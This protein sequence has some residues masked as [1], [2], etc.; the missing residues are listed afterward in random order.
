M[1][2]QDPQ[3]SAER[4]LALALAGAYPDA[5][6]AFDEALDQGQGATAA[7]PKALL[8]FHLGHYESVVDLLELV[9]LDAHPGR[10][11]HRSEHLLRE[12]RVRIGRHHV[13]LSEDA[14]TA[15]FDAGVA[16]YHAGAMH[17][18]LVLFSDVLIAAPAHL[19]AWNNKAHMLMELGELDHALVCATISIA[20]D[21]GQGLGWCTL[22]EIFARLGR[23]TEALS[24]FEH[25]FRREPTASRAR[26]I[27]AELSKLAVERCT[28]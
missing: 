8:L 27:D 20:I 10:N 23:R 5:L 2:E 21:P 6:H 7:Y 15:K 26:C 1:R 9:P 19:T 22:G 24:C 16:A 11:R 12:C 4:G 17:D 28:S 18:S 14:I 3:H 13:E 25:S